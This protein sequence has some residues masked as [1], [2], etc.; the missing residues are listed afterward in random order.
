MSDQGKGYY[1]RYYCRRP[2]EAN[3][4]GGVVCHMFVVRINVFGSELN[5]GN[6]RGFASQ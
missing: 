1:Y 4:D 6:P 2:D 3:G 5:K